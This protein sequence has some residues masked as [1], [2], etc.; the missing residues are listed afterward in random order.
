MAAAIARVFS[1]C[2]TQPVQKDGFEILDLCESR[3]QII[4]LISLRFPQSE[5]SKKVREP[6]DTLD[7]R[8]GGRL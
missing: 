4:F 2:A 3:L 6:R 7:F 8:G 1:T 5:K